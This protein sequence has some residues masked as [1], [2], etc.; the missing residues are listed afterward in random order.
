MAVSEALSP[1]RF[2][3]PGGEGAGCRAACQGPARGRGGRVPSRH[4]GLPASKQR[5]KADPRPPP[6]SQRCVVAAT[7]PCLHGR[8]A[9]QLPHCAST[10]SHGLCMQVPSSPG[11]RHTPPT[12]HAGLPRR[13]QL[14]A[15]EE[16]KALA[17][18]Q[19]R[20][21]VTSR[22]RQQGRGRARQHDRCAVGLVSGFLSVLYAWAGSRATSMVSRLS[23]VC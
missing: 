18:I 13:C 23:A 8:K 10:A 3:F 11:R 15:E 4:V 17:Y 9:A 21:D 6:K 22:R 1:I 7:W 12:T 20:R 5:P 19:L 14:E 2:P 16:R